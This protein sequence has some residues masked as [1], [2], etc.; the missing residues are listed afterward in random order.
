MSFIKPDGNVLTSIDHK[1]ES[2]L[3][4]LDKTSF[5]EK[6]KAYGIARDHRPDILFQ[7]HKP[8]DEIGQ[9][10]TNWVNDDGRIV[11]DGSDHPIRDFPELPICISSAIG[12]HD[13]NYYWRQ[14]EYITTYDILCKCWRTASNYPRLTKI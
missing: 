8:R 1:K 4:P 2:G 14:N 5:L 10:P 3:D 7:I 11:L 12:G 6:D 9:R 13:I